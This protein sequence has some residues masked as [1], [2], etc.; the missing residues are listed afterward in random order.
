LEDIYGKRVKM[1]LPK[2]EDF[3]ERLKKSWEVAKKSMKIAK[4]V[5]KKQFNKKRWNPQE[6]KKGD[7]M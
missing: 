4:K 2:L 1:E 6:L 3:L 7:N 5:M